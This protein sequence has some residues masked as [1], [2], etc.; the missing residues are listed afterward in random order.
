MIKIARLGG[1]VE[2]NGWLEGSTDCPLSRNAKF[3]N[4]PHK[5]NIFMKPTI[6]WAVTVLVL[7]VHHWKR[8]R[9]RSQED[10]WIA[11]AALPPSPN[12]GHVAQSKNLHTQEREHRDE[13]TSHWTQYRPV[14]VESKT[15]LNSTDDHPGRERSDE[16]GAELPSRGWEPEFLQ[17]SPPRA[18]VLWGHK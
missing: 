1:E 4:Y 10:F 17:A 8:P 14:T 2:Q 16:P 6:R 5:E 15:R 12:S 13:E 7:T 18:K 9:R 3:N 11:S